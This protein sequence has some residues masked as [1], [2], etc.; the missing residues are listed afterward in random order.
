VP[1]K[2]SSQTAKAKQ[3]SGLRVL[4]PAKLDVTGIKP[5]RIH[6]YG[7]STRNS[8]ALGLGVGRGCNGSNACFVAAF[9]AERGGSVAYR[10]KVSLIRGITGYFKPVTCGASCSPAAVQWMQRGVLYEIQFKGATQQEEKATMTSL[11]N[12]AIRG[13]AR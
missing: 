11:A 7:S 10:R 3:K 4:L 9:L 5:S 1:A 13:G 8:Y 12:K 6:G 2:L